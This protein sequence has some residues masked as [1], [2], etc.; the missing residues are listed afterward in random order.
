M[1]PDRFVAALRE[2][3]PEGHDYPLHEPTFRGR[4]KELLLDCVDST[5]VS[6]V[7]RWVDQMEADL[8]RITGAARAVVVVNGTA[9]LQM[10]LTLAG[11]KPGDLV[12]CPSLT[13]T[14][15]AP[16]SVVRQTPPPVDPM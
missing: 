4:E 14:Q 6:S 1:T 9:A 11:V 16:A 10:A 13:L 12:I 8:Q 7:G 3:L 15:V 2:V 5:F